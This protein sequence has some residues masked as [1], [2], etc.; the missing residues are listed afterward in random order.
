MSCFVLRVQSIA[1]STQSVDH[2]V[3]LDVPNISRH[4]Q[5]CGP[6]RE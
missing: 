6:S 2:I 1:F 5:I 3:L 4:V